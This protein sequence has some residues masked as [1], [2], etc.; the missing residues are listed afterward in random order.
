M[1]IASVIN[2]SGYMYKYGPAPPLKLWSFPEILTGRL[3]MVLQT[4]SVK[5]FTSYIF[6]FYEKKISWKS[7]Q[8]FPSGRRN[9][10]NATAIQLGLLLLNCQAVEL[11]TQIF[12]TPLCIFKYPTKENSHPNQSHP[13]RQMQ[14]IHTKSPLVSTRI[15]LT[16]SQNKT[17]QTTIR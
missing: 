12:K 4:S 16:R 9:T 7:L 3:K 5:V 14:G 15:K 11:S 17:Q 8:A 2:C 6:E 13:R 1:N 10:N